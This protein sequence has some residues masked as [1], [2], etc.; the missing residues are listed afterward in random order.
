MP[1]H[2]I[3]SDGLNV[4]L[5]M[6][7]SGPRITFDIIA[8]LTDQGGENLKVAALIKA[9]MQNAID[10]RIK[11]STMPLEDEA[12]QSNPN[13]PDFFWDGPD[14]VARSVIVEDVVWDGTRYVPT[15][16]RARQ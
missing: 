8:M 9:Q 4:T 5:W 6:D 16:R 3:Q 11:R 1:V 2:K 14:L 12:R 13:R 10:V 7:S 15:L